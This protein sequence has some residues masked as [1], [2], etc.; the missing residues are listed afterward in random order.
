[1]NVEQVSKMG[2]WKPTCGYTGKADS[3]GEASEIA[4]SKS[5]GIVAMA[6][7]EEEDRRNTGNPVT[8][9]QERPTGHPRGTGRARQGG[10]EVRSSDE[11]G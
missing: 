9:S 7:M 5:T 3:A 11:A 6:C 8:W 10:G 1:M 4:T 2:M